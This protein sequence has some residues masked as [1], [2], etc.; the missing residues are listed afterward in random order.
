MT[1][2][3]RGDFTVKMAPLA[4][5]APEGSTHG[6]MSLDKTYSGDLTATGKG[7]MIAIRPTP[8]GSGVYMALERVQGAIDGRAGAFSL[9]HRG[10]MHRGVQE[11][12]ITIVPDSGDGALAGIAGAMKLEIHDGKHSYDLEYTLPPQ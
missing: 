12:L 10:V 4:A 7:E 6:R 8:A 3:V 1:L 5:D 11:L 9:A 2:H